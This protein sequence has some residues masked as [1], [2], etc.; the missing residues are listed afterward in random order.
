[1]CIALWAPVWG[2]NGSLWFES[3]GLRR[4]P[5]HAT[6]DRVEFAEEIKVDRQWDGE[7]IG[8]PSTFP[9]KGTR[10]FRQEDWRSR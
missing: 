4:L 7:R 2:T 8:K 9:A 3:D 1:M 5:K 10:R 6:C